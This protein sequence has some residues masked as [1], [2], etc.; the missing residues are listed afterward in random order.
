MPRLLP[1]G[2]SY[3][4]A[5]FSPLEQKMKVNTTGFRFSASLALVTILGPSAIDMYLASLPDMA[6][7]LNASFTSIQL[8]LTVFLLAMGFGQLIFGPVIDALGR[9]RPLLAGILFFAACSVWAAYSRSIDGLLYARFFQGLAASLTLVV[10]IS[11]VR[12][13]ADGTAAAKLFAL[14][15][16]IEGL[17]P[18]MAPAVGGYVDAHFGWRAVMFVL[19]A[20]AVLALLN[21]S[22]NLPETLPLD[23]RTSLKPG[24]ITRNYLRLLTDSRFI[25]PALSLSAAFFF[26][27]VY[28]GGAPLVYQTHYALAPD[29]FGLVFGATGTAVLLG[30]LTTGRWVSSSSLSGVVIRGVMFMAAGA[31]LAGI[32]AASGVGLPGIVVGM[33][34]AMFGLGIA[35]STLMSVTMSSQTTSLGSAAALLGALQLILSSAATPL[36]GWLAGQSTAHW[37]GFL[38]IFGLFVVAMTVSAIR[39]AGSDVEYVPGH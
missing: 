11:M 5:F 8:T 25:L 26:L 18:V 16:T 27:F 29:T 33:F 34:I 22:V 38:V 36:A 37:L 35:E 39:H 1:T 17:A 19:A 24:A 2:R 14:M 15:M 31:V 32:S 30:A 28:I 21:T 20:M 23:K 13:V 3:K 6:S 4:L 9:R 7:E 10:A 12:D